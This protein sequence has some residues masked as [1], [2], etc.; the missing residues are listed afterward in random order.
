MTERKARP[1]EISLRHD[2][3]QSDKPAGLVFIGRIRSPW[4]DR[5]SAPHNMARARERGRPAGIE[6]DAAFRPGLK[7]LEGHSHIIVLYWLN[8]A[9]RDL[10]VQAPSHAPGPMGAFALRSP[11][12]PNPIGLSVAAIVSLDIQTGVIGIDAI[13]CVDKTPLLDIKPYLPS[14]DAVADADPG[15]HKAHK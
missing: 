15:W 5:A 10:I 1:G 4:I 12:R 9:R 11:V 2:P 13:D 7:G 14:I 3:A 6:V 8:S